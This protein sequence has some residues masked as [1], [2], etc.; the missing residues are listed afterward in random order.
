VLLSHNFG[1]Q[2]IVPLTIGSPITSPLQCY[3]SH[4]K[5]HYFLLKPLTSHLVTAH[6]SDFYRS[7]LHFSLLPKVLYYINT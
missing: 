6:A 3:K 5:A 1:V 2:Y 7:S 4:L